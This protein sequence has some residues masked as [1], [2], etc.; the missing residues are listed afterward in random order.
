MLSFSSGAEQAGHSALP[1][2]WDNASWLTDMYSSSEL[3]EDVCVAELWVC[4]HGIRD[5]MMAI[6]LL[7]EPLL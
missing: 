7:P 4:Q 6:S 2:A 1:A 3:I 5:V